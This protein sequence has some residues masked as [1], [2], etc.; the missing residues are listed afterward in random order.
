MR[1]REPFT[2]GLEA[3]RMDG[4]HKSPP[5]EQGKQP[6]LPKRMC[7]C[8]SDRS[9]WHDSHNA[10]ALVK[11]KRSALYHRTKRVAFMPTLQDIHDSLSRKNQEASLDHLSNHATMDTDDF[12]YEIERF[13]SS[14]ISLCAQ[15]S[16]SI[17]AIPST[18]SFLLSI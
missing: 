10:A 9:A 7:S 18:M 4:Y 16:S 11:N 3:L 14:N 6:L 13:A 8:P 1:L 17:A 5:P 2:C 12:T 15:A